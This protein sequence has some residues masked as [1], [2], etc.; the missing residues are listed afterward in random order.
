[1][2]VTLNSGS[3]TAIMSG[4]DNQTGIGLVEVYDLSPAP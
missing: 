1:M 3:Y 4:F 2:H